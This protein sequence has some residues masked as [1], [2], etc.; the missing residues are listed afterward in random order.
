MVRNAVRR[1]PRMTVLAALALALS[2]AACG[3]KGPLDP[4]PSANATPQPSEQPQNTAAPPLTDQNGK[5]MAAPGQKR[6]LPMDVL[7][8]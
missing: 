6:S 7:L 8:N 5:P 1:L 4:P 3:R 2:L